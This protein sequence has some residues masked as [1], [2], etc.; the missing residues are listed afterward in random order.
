MRSPAHSEDWVGRQQEL[1]RLCDAMEKRESLLIWGD[2]DAGKTALLGKAIGQ[3]PTDAQKACLYAD[4]GA[5]V[6]EIL[7]KLVR[8]LWENG[9][10]RVTEKWRAAQGHHHMVSAWLREQSGGQLS[11]MVCGALAEQPCWIFLDHAPPCTHSVAKF[12]KN[13]MWRWNTPVYTVARGFSPVEA[14]QAWSLYWTDKYRLHLGPLPETDAAELLRLCI[15]RY[16]LIRLELE[17]F[18]EEVLRL[19]GRLPGAIVKMCALAAKP[20]YQYEQRIKTTLIHVDYLMGKQADA[21]G[22]LESFE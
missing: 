6:K 14:G 17:D 11:R 21:F 5:S 1:R 4:G 2:A 13:L 7:L 16:A 10:P 20:K 22:H 3:S 12:L 9:H 15:R 19:S 18:R 8:S